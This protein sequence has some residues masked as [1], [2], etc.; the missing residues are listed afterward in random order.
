MGETRKA[1]TEKLFNISMK[2]MELLESEIDLADADK[3]VVLRIC[4][5]KI[6]TE[7]QMRFIAM[8]TRN[9]MLGKI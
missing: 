4:I 2:V 8:H 7:M 3:Q 1:E 5:A 6:E 9:I